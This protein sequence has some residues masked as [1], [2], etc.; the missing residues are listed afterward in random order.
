MR[1]LVHHEASDGFVDAVRQAADPD[2]ELV[3]V[4][5][6]DRDGLA[7]ALRTA[8]AL[9]HVLEPLDRATLAGAPRLR[10]VQKIGV[11][12]NTIDLDACR[13]L[14]I[15]VAN[16]PGTNTQAVV[17]MT[18]GLMLAASRRITDLDRAVR[19]GAGFPADPGALDACSE[20]SG[21]TVGLVGYGAIGRGVARVLDAFGA[22]TIVHV[23]EPARA[24][25]REVVPLDELFDRSDVISLHVP[26]TTDTAGI[27]S[28]ARLARLRRTAILVNTA[29]GGL[30]DQPALVAALA[31]GSLRAAG[32]DVFAD[33]PID[34]RDPLF[35]LPNVVVTPHVAWRTVETL[36][37]SFQIGF[38]N[39]RRAM[40][41]ERLLH[42]IAPCTRPIP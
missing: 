30:V 26:L 39:C 36:T 10:L 23:R 34:A 7:G 4:R 31:S 27:V 28:R 18:I 16:M 20:L 29:R 25:E 9:L 33:E 13:D 32:L 22:T 14:G 3:F 2:T 8:D 35:A 40:R 37:R 42:E 6:T 21:K 41:G 17:E 15:G 11:G 1:V 38:E 19:V 12:V 24:S 5:E